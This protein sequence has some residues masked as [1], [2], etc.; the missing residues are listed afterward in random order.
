ML[1]QEILC[2]LSGGGLRAAFFHA[3]VLRALIRLGLKQNIKLVSSVSGGS[4]IGA[5]F[6]LTFDEI[7]DVRSF[8]RLIVEPLIKLSNKNLRNK[9]LLYN[10]LRLPLTVFLWLGNILGP[11]GKPFF[12]LDRL[13]SNSML[14]NEL[15]DMLFANSTL[16]SL[17]ANLQVIINATNLNTGARWRFS[18][19]DFGD[20]KTGYSYDIEHIKI[21]DVVA[22]SICHPILFSPYKLPVKQCIFHLRNAQKEDIGI[23]PC[24]PDAVY[25]SDG[26][27]YDNLGLHA[28]KTELARNPNSFIVFSDASNLIADTTIAYS[29]ANSFIRIMDILIEQ[30]INR[31]R[32]TTIHNFLQNIW[33]GIYFKL[34]NTTHYYRYLEH[35]S[36]ADAAMVPD[37][38][39]PEPIVERI[40]KIPV[41]LNSFIP[42]E[43]DALIYHGETLTE[44]LLAKWHSTL[45]TDLVTLPDYCPLQKP[46]RAVQ[47]FSTT[48]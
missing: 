35:P 9:A 7:H 32:D 30:V 8:D 42:A 40:N 45:Y 44:T 27:I 15:D 38:G 26:G 20:Y 25:L 3:G 5:L 19:Q 48:T 12:L 24:P 46:D 14:T 17:S 39:W 37:I 13:N 43:I 4:I 29:Y 33:Q 1:G 10:I 31:D 41:D 47:L 18:N 21:S 16:P 22:A 34:E 6:G 28:L 2:A 23:N 36:A 11:M